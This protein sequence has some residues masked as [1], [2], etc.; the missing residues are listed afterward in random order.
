[1]S[2]SFRGPREPAR[3]LRARERDE[4]ARHAALGDGPRAP[5]RG[6]R[7]ERTV[8]LAGRD[9]DRDRFQR[10]GIEGIAAGSVGETR[11]LKLVALDTPGP[12]ARHE[13]AAAPEGDLAAHPPM[14]VRAAGGV[15]DV[16]RPAELRAILFHHRAQHLL[17]R[18][19]AEAEE[20]RARV[21]EDIEQGQGQ[22]DRG[23]GSDRV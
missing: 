4:A 11:Q 9:A 14:A 5:P 2:R 12:Q 10:A 22:L 16:L 23:D 3:Q 18:L 19:E 20:R 1:M 8:I 7:V 13:D 17:A 6:E 21:G 15:G